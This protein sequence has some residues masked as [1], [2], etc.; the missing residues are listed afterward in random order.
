[1]HQKRALKHKC[2]KEHKIA[3]MFGNVRK[4][5]SGNRWQKNLL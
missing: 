1:M 2:E 4:L 5:V 3:L